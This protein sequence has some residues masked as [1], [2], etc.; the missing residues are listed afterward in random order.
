MTKTSGQT[1]NKG[2]KTSSRG[3]AEPR[4]SRQRKPADLPVDDW[5]RALRRQFGREQRFA[6]ENL[7]NDPVFSDFAVF[8]PDSSRRYR[9]AIRGAQPGDNYCTCPDFATNDLGTCKHIEFT[10]G[11]ITT[12][13]AGKNAL[14]A[15]FQGAFS[16]LF[17]D[18]SGQRRVRLR[19]ANAFPAELQPAVGRL[20]DPA[21]GWQL[22][23]ADF[24]S[25]PAFIDSLRSTGHDLRCHDD[26][27]AFIAEV[28][29]GEARRQALAALYPIG[30]D[31]PGLQALL[32]VALYPYQ[33][34]GAL[35]AVRAGRALIGDEMGLG[36]TVQAIAAMEI[37]AR[38][39]AVER[40]LIVCPTSLK[41]QWER[42]IARFSERRATVIGGLRA[43]RQ[44]RYAQDDFC[45]I[46][47]YETLGRDLDLIQGWAP[48]V[49]IVDEAQ[50]IKN[51]NTIAA[52]ALKRIDSPYALVLT[53][54]PLENRLE[55]L[56]SIVQFVDQHRLG[57]TW[58]LLDEHQQRDERGRVI[59]YRNLQQIGQTLAPIMLRRRKAAVLEQLPE[60]VDNTL[61]V[62]MTAQQAL[63]HD[64]NG[65]IVARIVHRWRHTGFLSEKDQLRLRCSMQNMRMSCNSTFLLD[66][67]TD[68][69][70][71]ADELAALLDD[72]LDDP[73]AKVVI[74]S[75]WLRTHELIIRRL[76][77]RGW[78]HVLFHG[79]VPGDKR[80]ALV[81]RFNQDPE[82]RAFLS[83]DAGG[84]G[85]NLQHA[86]AVVINMDLPWNPAVL[87]QRI[88]RV[89]RMGQT[90][91]VQVINFV[92]RGT[93]EEG[94]LSV[95]AFKQSLF[96]GV[97]DGGESE[98]VLHG[99]K[100]SK[101]ME[102][103]EQVAGA[104]ES[105]AA[106]EDDR[107]DTPPLAATSD[108][109][110]DEAADDH[111]AAAAPAPA[112]ASEPQ[113]TSAAE[114]AAAAEEPA[115]TTTETR[116]PGAA[117]PWAPLLAVGAQLLGELAAA[118]QGERESS[119]LQTD[120][121][122]GQ[123]YLRLPVPDPQTVHNLADSLLK[124]LGKRK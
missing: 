88:G 44:A 20:F 15:G 64:E 26:A 22:S 124:L 120:P 83:T 98:V 89:H 69:G 11:Q 79:G 103:V 99:T 4:L 96:A 13:P 14:E 54:T 94:M 1:S 110:A 61:F 21:R 117:D 29:D 101:F 68:Y 33:R 78:Q 90:R 32:K 57:P 75:Q 74:F 46:T 23:P 123:R 24:T 111:P 38:H 106:G 81:D 107:H 118:S 116:T 58:R 77:E 119:L 10:L 6:L 43:V 121:Q 56:I 87:E 37:F 105:Q 122:T 12:E 42:E 109:D 19:L 51:W 25:L 67:E 93:I 82:C 16:E 17:L 104:V 95:L 2:R 71:K 65:A 45:K 41:H 7:G 85:L 76:N 100:L 36:K 9:V 70:Y 50:R 102:T 112:A 3:A 114:P 62:P 49:V 27:L 97:L 8:N 59:G 28:R 31:S 53:G 34:E 91:G 48:D 84:V 115:V 108:S 40:V 35:F 52:R 55:E 63:H 18:Y 5:Q 73:Q 113:T 86:A 47:N 60:R 30:A 72:I 92:A 39:F 66:H 80:G